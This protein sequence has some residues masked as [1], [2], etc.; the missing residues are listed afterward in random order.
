MK[1]KISRKVRCEFANCKKCAKDGEKYCIIHLN[2]QKQVH[3][4]EKVVK[5]TEVECLKFLKVDTELRNAIQG[6]RIKELEINNFKQEYEIQSSK[7]RH[8]LM[9]LKDNMSIY[10]KNNKEF[11]LYLSKKYG[12]ISEDIVI[13]TDT[14]IIRDAKTR[15]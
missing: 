9:L 6:V 2:Q 4:I 1:N 11:V 12:I 14:R 5:V 10:L 8:E 7:M 13:D 15:S 3:P